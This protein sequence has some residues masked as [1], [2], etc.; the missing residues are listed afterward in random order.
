ME[1]FPHLS[2]CIMELTNN[3]ARFYFYNNLIAEPLTCSIRQMED[4]SI[5][6]MVNYKL[7]LRIDDIFFSY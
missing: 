5:I 1:L 6:K 7:L 3:V 4:I 2:I